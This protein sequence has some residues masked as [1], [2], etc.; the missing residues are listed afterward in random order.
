M[1]LVW[2]HFVAPVREDLFR[3]TK[4]KEYVYFNLKNQLF[5]F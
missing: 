1:Y 3:E 4:T 5:F 2:I